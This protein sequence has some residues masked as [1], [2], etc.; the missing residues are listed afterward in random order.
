MNETSSAPEWLHIGG[1]QATIAFALYLALSI[2]FYAFGVILHPSQAYIGQN[3]DPTFY[4]WS[5]VWWPHALLQH[6]NPFLPTVI[7]APVGFNL[8]WAASCPGPSLLLYPITRLFGPV[9]A[10]NLVCLSAP[11]IA[12][13]TA[14]VLCR[15]V[16]RQFLPSLLGG[17]IFGFSSYM[18]GHMLGHLNLFLIFPVPLALLLLLFRLDRR[19]NGSAFVALLALV[20][21]FE[22]LTSTEVFATASLFGALAIS[23][24][25]L[26]APSEY[27][28][29]ITSLLPEIICAYAVTAIVL[30]PYLYY[31]FVRR[32]PPR[33]N[34]ASEFSSD[35][36]NFF[37]PTELTWIG[38]VHFAPVVSHFRGNISENGAY[39]GAPL[40]LVI[41]LFAKSHWR[42]PLTDFLL[43][44][45]VVVALASL[46]PTMHIAGEATIPLPWSVVSHLPLID[47]ALPARFVMYLFLIAG[48]LAALYTSDPCRSAAVRLILGILCFLF[49]MPNVTYFR[50]PQVGVT[51]ADTPAFFSSGIYK[52]YISPAETVLVLPYGY[53]GAS[54]LWQAQAGMG[55]RMAEGY[56]GPT[57]Q[58]FL[59]WPILGDLY[60]GHAGSQFYRQLPMFL[61][62]HQVKAIIVDLHH[63]GDWP[64]WLKVLGV[65]PIEVGGV[66]F[67]PV[68]ED[69]AMKRNFS[70][71]HE[72]R[73]H[74]ELA[75][76]LERRGDLKAAEREYEELVRLQPDK[77]LYHYYLYL[78][79]KRLGRINRANEEYVKSLPPSLVPAPPGTD[80]PR[81][82][83][84]P[85]AP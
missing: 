43:A 13:W 1:L 42:E 7:C 28:T 82:Q 81:P 63:Q 41:L 18:S 54:M 21:T 34:S 48:V 17:Y 58:E 4:M 38:H 79:E 64:Q 19:L 23:L 69:A 71:Y 68:P 39:L 49:L 30:I 47:Q 85:G 78:V 77:A 33:F 61:E 12:A 66:L 44:S 24:A 16:T 14:F 36:L 74:G 8:T 76:Q 2:Y 53:T 45:L 10:Y 27:R 57:P 20:L 80:Q 75:L 25:L 46:G 37:L 62:A 15:Y 56:V 50:I 84:T 35:L 70:G 60:S 52:R 55:F 83:S 51:S 11:A 6:L 73:Y 65:S 5:F 67:Y 40:M 26:L 32:E 31:V 3:M 29:K 59:G 22:F 72:E 9:V